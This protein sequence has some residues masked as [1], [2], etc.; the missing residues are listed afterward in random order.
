[1]SLWSRVFK[2]VKFIYSQSVIIN[3]ADSYLLTHNLL[4]FLAVSG[5]KW[6]SKEKTVIFK[7][8]RQRWLA[9]MLSESPGESLKVPTPAMLREDSFFPLLPLPWEDLGTGGFVAFILILDLWKLKWKPLG[10]V[11]MR[12]VVLLCSEI[13][14]RLFFRVNHVLVVSW[15]MLQFGL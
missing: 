3:T 2:R 15:W 11:G 1:M 12:E 6:Q 14:L 7:P 8:P 4:W 13:V 10:L 9:L 5:R